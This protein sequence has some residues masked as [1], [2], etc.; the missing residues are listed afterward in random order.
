LPCSDPGIRARQVADFKA[1]FSAVNPD[2]PLLLCAGNHDVGDRPT[3]ENIN[4]YKYAFGI[5]IL[6]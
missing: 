1:V 3:A 6:A 2:I 4:A 5:A